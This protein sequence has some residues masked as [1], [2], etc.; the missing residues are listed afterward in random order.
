MHNANIEKSLDKDCDAPYHFLP[1]FA[2]VLNIVFPPFTRKVHKTNIIHVPRDYSTLQAA[3]DNVAENGPND[4]TI[5]VD[6]SYLETTSIKIK[7]TKADNFLN[8]LSLVSK[9]ATISP[10]SD[11]SLPGIEIDG[12][13]TG[14]KIKG[15]NIIATNGISIKNAVSSLNSVLIKNNNI[16]N[17]QKMPNINSS[18]IDV[19]LS[20]SPNTFYSSAIIITNNKISNFFRGI[21]TKLETGAAFNLYIMKIVNNTISS[22]HQPINDLSAVGMALSAAYTYIADNTVSVCGGIVLV[23]SKAFVVNNIID[24]DD[25]LCGNS[26]PETDNF[27]ILSG[28]NIASLIIH[29]N[30]ISHHYSGINYHAAHSSIGNLA[31]YNTFSDN[32]YDIYDSPGPY[33]GGSANINY[34]N[35]C[36]DGRSD[37][38][39]FIKK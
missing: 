28:L 12:P 14:I 34:H 17:L 36:S 13:L 29:Q 35:Y 11:L 32:T 9:G 31:S 39:L 38:C 19:A 22:N 2:Q 15:F 24:Y 30:K 3:I 8:G 5:R 37:E 18:G 21:S 4:T 6:P 10:Q 27:G 23:V 20:N 26:N 1:G 7:A 33:D 25:T 16:K